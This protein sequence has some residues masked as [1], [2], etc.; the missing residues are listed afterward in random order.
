MPKKVKH[1]K[2]QRGGRVEGKAGRRNKL[3]AE[4]KF[5]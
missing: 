1:R 2:V 5:G 4:E 3:S